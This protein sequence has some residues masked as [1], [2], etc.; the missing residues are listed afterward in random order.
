MN[1]EQEAR[2]SDSTMQRYRTF[3]RSK[4]C[5]RGREQLLQAPPFTLEVGGGGACTGGGTGFCMFWKD[6]LH[7]L[8]G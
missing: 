3:D 4:V 6:L 1:V 8:D 7:V 5:R 2:D